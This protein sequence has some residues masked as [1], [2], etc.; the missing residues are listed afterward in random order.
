MA[1]GARAQVFAA[2]FKEA[3]MARLVAVA[4]MMV[5]CGGVSEERFNAMEA[6]VKQMQSAVS[7]TGEADPKIAALEQR[8]TGFESTTADSIKKLEEMVEFLQREVSKVASDAKASGSTPAASDVWVDVDQLLGIEVEGIQA[9]GE[10][11]QV[12]KDW[13]VSKLRAMTAGGRGPKLVEARKGGVSIKGIKP[14]S[15]ADQLGLK[16]NDIVTAV[17]DTAVSSVAELSAALHIGKT[18]TTVKLQRRKKE[19]TLT[20]TLSE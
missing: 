13:L 12:K 7:A 6:Q 16:N 18:P 4:V 15:L 8:L 10:N 20:Y 9:D 2:L 1:C 17:N 5:G 14:K 19:V 3:M 11:Y